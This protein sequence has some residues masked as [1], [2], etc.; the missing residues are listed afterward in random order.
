ME[1]T[2]QS[3]STLLV[4]AGVIGTLALVIVLGLGYLLYN[5]GGRLCGIA[6]RFVTGTLEHM[7][8]MVLQMDS[9][10]EVMKEIS[11][12]QKEIQLSQARLVDR[13]EDLH[14]RSL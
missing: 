1:E 9:H 7:G 6:D 3:I 14:R 5:F 10:G 11:D 2:A 12:T 13:V 8:E 4:N